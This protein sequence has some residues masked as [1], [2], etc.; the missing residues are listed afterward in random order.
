MLKNA[1]F[2]LFVSTLFLTSCGKDDDSGKDLD[3][4]VIATFKGIERGP[5]E[6]WTNVGGNIESVALADTD[7]DEDEVFTTDVEEAS[8]I[9]FNFNSEEEVVIIGEGDLVLPDS[10]VVAYTCSD[11]QISFPLT[12]GSITLT[13]TADGTPEEFE[14]ASQAYIETDGDGFSISSWGAIVEDVEILKNSLEEGATIAVM[15]Y[16]EKYSN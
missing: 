11:D 10:S 4:P 9:A 14:L 15:N 7:L 1:L 2:F 13:L 12:F 16:T 6:V 8:Y 5:I 3:Y